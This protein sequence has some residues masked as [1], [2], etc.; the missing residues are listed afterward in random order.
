M[1]LAQANALIREALQKPWRLHEKYPVDSWELNSVDLTQLTEED[2]V[3]QE[4]IAAKYGSWAMER[5]E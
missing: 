3:D 1:T 5:N 4:S 2:S